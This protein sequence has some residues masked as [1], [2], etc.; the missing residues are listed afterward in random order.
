MTPSSS[1]KPKPKS[2]SPSPPCRGGFAPPSEG[3]CLF[4]LQCSAGL[5]SQPASLFFVC[6]GR[7]RSVRSWG[8]SKLVPTQFTSARGA[9]ELSP[10]RKPWEPNPQKSQ[11]LEARH[12][13]RALSPNH[14]HDLIPTMNLAIPTEGLEDY[15][16]PSQRARVSQSLGAIAGQ[17][18]CNRFS[19]R[20]LSRGIS[21]EK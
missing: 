12:L 1:S 8:S 4:N 6:R 20:E 16:S 18:T 15:E 9:P 5:L 10:G 17:H 19:L 14:L 3:R 11:A 13:L 2:S 7:A 21:I